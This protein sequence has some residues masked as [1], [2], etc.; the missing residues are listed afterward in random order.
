VETGKILVF[1]QD[2][3]LRE[4]VS[5]TPSQVINQLW[6]HT[7][8]TLTTQQATSKKD[9]SLRPVSGKKKKLETLL[10]NN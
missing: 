5:D 8:V 3:N 6:W 7:P 1:N 10:K 4:K 2:L 9:C